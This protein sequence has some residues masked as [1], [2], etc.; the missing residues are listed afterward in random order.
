M[1]QLEL[2]NAVP[3]RGL[4]I[5]VFKALTVFECWSCDEALLAETT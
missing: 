1:D 4:N 2:H 5:C 3:K